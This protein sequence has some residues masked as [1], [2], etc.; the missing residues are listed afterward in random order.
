M[1]FK[2]KKAVL[3]R[4]VSTTDQKNFGNSLNSQKSQLLKWCATN[5]VEILRDFEEDH[6]AKTFKRPAFEELI[7]YIYDHPRKVNLLLVTKWDRF[8]RDF[9]G[10]EE[11]ERFLASKGVTVLDI[12]S[13]IDPSDEYQWLSKVIYRALPEQENRIKSVRVKEGMRQGLK[14]GR[15]NNKAPKG[16]L[17]MR[18][19]EGKPLIQPDSECA[20]LVGDLFEEY[21][22]GHM[23]QNQLLLDPRF[24]K[25]KLSKSTISRM[26]CNP[27]YAGKVFIPAYRDE[28]EQL[29]DGRHVA[30]VSWRTFQQVQDRI[31]GRARS[32]DKPGALNES[33][34]LRGHLKC[35]SCGSNLTGSRSRSKTGKYYFYYHCNPRVGCKHR[36][37]VEQHHKA[38][39]ELFSSFQ[40][41]DDIKN[42]F[43]EI[44]KDH[45]EAQDEK[46]FKQIAELEKALNS[47]HARREEMIG[48]LIAGKLDDHIIQRAIEKI[49]SD[50]RDNEALLSQLNEK[51][52][53]IDEFLEF[54]MTLL[55]HL[56]DF[57]SQASPNTK[58]QL[59]SSILSEKLELKGKKYRT[60]TLKPGFNHIYQSVK[61][62]QRP[63]KKK[64]E[65]LSELSLSVP[66]AGLEPA[67]PVRVNRF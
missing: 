21:A 27:T 50:S 2:G 17:N 20:K 56:G 53:G 24:K 34:P 38:L 52:N 4:R 35:P 49:D 6:S 60:P 10:A 45:F 59:L 33:F 42:V 15:Y 26:L 47:L 1:N 39:E 11:F 41:H 40:P 62:L 31:S 64:G 8:S 29:I 13:P 18:D 54:G 55:S 48:K 30:L 3:Y 67:R 61:K 63:K 9:Y 51:D 28:P 43:K 44:L 7:Q 12:S 36:L 58:K 22:R 57:F 66:G 46:H 32:K 5:K 23:S 25:L 19:E 16:Y 65:P 14:D 37:P